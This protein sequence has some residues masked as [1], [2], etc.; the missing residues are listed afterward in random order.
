MKITICAIGKIK[1]GPEHELL[2]R[3]QRRIFG[4]LKILELEERRKSSARELKRREADLIRKAM[5]Q[6]S[7]RIAMDERGNSLSSREFATKL[8]CWQ[9][10]NT[11]ITFMIGGAGGLE[12]ELRDGANTVLALGAATWP[13]QLT[14]VLLVEQIYRAQA[15][16]AGHPYH[17]D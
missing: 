5:P 8:D 12:K 10:Q 6:G 9:K 14:R 4:P 3:Y 13:H 15:I 2:R 7:L 1:P 17:R 16:L 11:E